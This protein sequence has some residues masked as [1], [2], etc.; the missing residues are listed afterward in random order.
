MDSFCSNP[1]LPEKRWDF[2][3]KTTQRPSNTECGLTKGSTRGY[4]QHCGLRAVATVGK[5]V[6]VKELGR[7][8]KPGLM[9]ISLVGFLDYDQEH[10]EGPKEPN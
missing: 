1:V 2:S 10:R 3:L 4:F 5:E 9:D 8:R 7:G 6:S